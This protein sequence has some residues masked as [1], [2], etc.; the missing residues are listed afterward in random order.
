MNINVISIVLSCEI[1]SY[2]KAE[3]QPNVVVSLMSSDCERLK[4]K[5]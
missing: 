2:D 3:F 1:Q 5:K 4:T